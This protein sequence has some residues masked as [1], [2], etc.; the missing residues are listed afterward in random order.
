M[1]APYFE[2]F[3]ISMAI[4]IIVTILSTPRCRKVAK[5]MLPCFSSYKAHESDNEV[6]TIES[7]SLVDNLENVG[8]DKNSNDVHQKLLFRYLCVYL[9]ATMSDWFQGPY[10]YALYSAYGFSQH[11]IAVLFVAG[12]G[13]SMIF[14]SFVGSMADAG[15]RKKYVI[16]FCIVYSASCLTK[17]K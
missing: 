5:V 6:D 7:V 8:N 4:N 10:V 11:D 12:F 3:V 1:A 17:R 14:G 16:I 15:G 2:L 9:F 13:S